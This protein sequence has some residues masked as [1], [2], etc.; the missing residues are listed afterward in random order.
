MVLFIV[1]LMVWFMVW[2]MVSI[3]MFFLNM[4]DY[5]GLGLETG[6]TIYLMRGPGT[7]QSPLLQGTDQSEIPGHGNTPGHWLVSDVLL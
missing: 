2:F 3:I 5:P 4:V 1:L 6:L 7:N